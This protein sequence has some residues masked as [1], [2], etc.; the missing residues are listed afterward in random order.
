MADPKGRGI[1]I[2]I[3]LPTVKH[4][5]DPPEPDADDKGGP[6]D[7]DQD[8]TGAPNPDWLDYHT[9]DQNCRACE[10][11]MDDGTCSVLKMPVGPT[12]WCKAFTP[13]QDQ[14]AQGPAGQEQPDA[15]NAPDYSS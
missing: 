7:N 9:G 1:G 4:P 13:T 2:M 3:G 11:M 15:G 5:D 14:N 8:D 10:H 6:S 12:D